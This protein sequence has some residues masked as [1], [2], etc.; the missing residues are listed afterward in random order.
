MD[1]R[2]HLAVIW[3]FKLVVSI[4]LIL[5]IAL[6]VFAAAK[7]SLVD[8]KPK[9]TYRK[10][11]IWQS[12]ATILLTQR[13]FPWGRSVFATG[14]DAG[15]DSAPTYFADPTRFSSLSAFY[16][17]LANSDAV[18]ARIP[19]TGAVTAAP[20]IDKTTGYAVQLPLLGLTAIATSPRVAQ[21]LAEQA[22]QAFITFIRDQQQA[23]EIPADQRVILELVNQPR[24]A[25]LVEGRKMTMPIVVFATVLIA[26]LGIAFI[27]ENLRP[28]VRPKS[29]AA[30]DDSS[31]AERA[32][33]TA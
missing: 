19:R 2:L 9:L 15:K 11:E 13:G 21:V 14:P 10:S 4:G 30:R 18:Q 32:Q 29:A 25:T 23:A 3:R 12:Q 26:A 22:A 28:G 24:G 20:I 8:G 31:N 5:A 1:L 6:S 17:K 27:L 7:P 16:A 33:R